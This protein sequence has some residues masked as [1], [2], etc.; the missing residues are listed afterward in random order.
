MAANRTVRVIGRTRILIVSIRIRAGFNH[1]GAPLGRRFAVAV[2]G[3]F[4]KPD[5]IRASH[6]GIP[7]VT[8]NR[9][10]EERLII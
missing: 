1:V 9:R 10:C 4:E 6:R 8:V 7:R 2:L 3:S 5:R